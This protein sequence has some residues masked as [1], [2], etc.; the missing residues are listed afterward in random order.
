MIG[1]GKFIVLIATDLIRRFL[2][3]PIFIP[4]PHVN[5]IVGNEGSESKKDDLQRS[6]WMKLAFFNNNFFLDIGLFYLSPADSFTEE[7]QG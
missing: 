1:N 3:C 5:R 6:L 2:P 7:P 4:T